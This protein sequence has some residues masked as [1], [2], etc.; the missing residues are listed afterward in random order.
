M[1]NTLL[2]CMVP[3]TL[4]FRPSQQKHYPPSRRLL[5]HVLKGMPRLELSISGLPT[6]AATGELIK[7]QVGFGRFAS[8]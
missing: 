4:L 3:A 7:A 5:F 6:A 1:L 8:Q 2:V